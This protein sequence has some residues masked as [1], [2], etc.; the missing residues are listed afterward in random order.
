MVIWSSY[1][2]EYREDIVKHRASYQD[3][4][5]RFFKKIF[6]C[7]K[8]IT[9]YYVLQNFLGYRMEWTIKV[10]TT[11]G[12]FYSAIVR[13]YKNYTSSFVAVGKK[14]FTT[15]STNTFSSV[16]KTRDSRYLWTTNYFFL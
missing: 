7:E 2:V 12:L 3:N 11:Q 5:L 14:G 8:V 4:K 13:K 1:R 9:W 15:R 16:D 6:Y 10:Y